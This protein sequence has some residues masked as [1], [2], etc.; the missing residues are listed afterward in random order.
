VID[1]CGARDF[2]FAFIVDAIRANAVDCVT[3]SL[4]PVSNFFIVKRIGGDFW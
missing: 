1:L 3:I 2:F 4:L